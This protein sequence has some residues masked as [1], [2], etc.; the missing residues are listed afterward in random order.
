MELN[1]ELILNLPSPP[2]S[3]VFC[4]TEFCWVAGKCDE[5]ELSS[6]CLHTALGCW[7]YLC[8]CEPLL[9]SFKGC[10]DAAVEKLPSHNCEVALCEGASDLWLYTETEFQQFYPQF[11]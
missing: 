1:Y 10:A 9:G 5:E 2:F 6:L 4:V 8:L 3:F 11:L 7:Q